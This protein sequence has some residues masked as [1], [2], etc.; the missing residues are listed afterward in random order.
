M[1]KLALILGLVSTTTMA[2][3][4]KILSW[5]RLNTTTN[6]FDTS[7]E[8]C[9]SLTPAPSAPTYVEVTV[10]K[11]SRS[12]AFYGAWIDQRGSSCQVVSSHRGRVEVNIPKMKLSL[13]LDQ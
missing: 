8:V 6:S 1:K 11:G 13:A 4:L 2:A 3:E 7:A 10:D 12:Q 9:F 5:S